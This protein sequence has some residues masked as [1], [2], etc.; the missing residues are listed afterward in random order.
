[1]T[2]ANTPPKKGSEKPQKSL[3]QIIIVDRSNV[4]RYDHDPV[5]VL[6]GENGVRLRSSRAE[7]FELEVDL[8]NYYSKELLNQKVRMR[9]DEDFLMDLSQER[10]GIYL[11][12]LTFPDGKKDERMIIKIE[13]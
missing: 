13:R 4:P 12:Q 1:M 8:T 6:K 11:L 2:T 9:P 10:E 3:Q 5:Q 7:E